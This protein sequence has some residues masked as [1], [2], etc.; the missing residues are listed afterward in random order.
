MVNTSPGKPSA[1]TSEALN[2]GQQFG[3]H[4]CAPNI[5]QH[6]STAVS[7]A[8]AAV[9]SGTKSSRAS[10]TKQDAKSKDILQTTEKT[11][12]APKGGGG[13]LHKNRIHESN[14]ELEAQ[15]KSNK[16]LGVRNQ[17]IRDFRDQER[18]HHGEL[19]ARFEEAKTQILEWE[20]FGMSLEQVLN[21]RDRQIRNLTVQ[22]SE[23]NQSLADERSSNKSIQL[24]LKDQQSRIRELESRVKSQE[25]SVTKAQ[26][27]AVKMLSTTI[28]S[29]MP[30]DSVRRDFGALFQALHSWARDNSVRDLSELRESS[31]LS[32]LVERKVL[33]DPEIWKPEHR[34]DIDSHT[35]PD[36]LL[37]A[38]VAKEVCSAF[39][40]TPFPFVPD[41]GKKISNESAPGSGAFTP[42]TASVLG[43]I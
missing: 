3:A 33:A 35:A 7:A 31:F 34:F 8:K 42:S 2:H 36:T 23:L 16:E 40:N 24:K 6:T 17:V 26:E 39:L 41:I 19:K 37:N 5:P 15:I 22:I 28:S 25:S 38:S 27:A 21:E 29:T 18:R 12:S 4:E 13:A 10:S 20:K 32:A 9:D 43:S 30:D 1:N 14:D 11:L